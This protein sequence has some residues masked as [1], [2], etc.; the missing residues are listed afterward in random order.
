MPRVIA[1]G[2]L[3]CVARLRAHC[4]FLPRTAAKHSRGCRSDVGPAAADRSGVNVRDVL[5]RT[6]VRCSHGIPLP[7][8]SPARA[9]WSPAGAVSPPV[10]RV[11]SAP[12]AFEGRGC[13]ARG[14]VRAFVASTVSRG[15]DAAPDGSERAASAV[16]P[17]AR[18]ARRSG[19]AYPCACPLARIAGVTCAARPLVQHAP[20]SWPVRSHASGVALACPRRSPMRACGLAYPCVPVRS[21]ACAC[22]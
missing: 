22:A 13:G 16:A 10:A 8:C 5:L 15:A 4:S 1:Y 12:R 9:S 17:C 6:V 21:P 19:L 14:P 3:R 20:R 18:P 2:L 7:P 11:I